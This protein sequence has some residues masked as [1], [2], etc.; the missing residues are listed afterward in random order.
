[1]RLGA[2]QGNRNDITRMARQIAK[3]PDGIV[4][5]AVDQMHILEMIAFLSSFSKI[6][7]QA[8]NELRG[9]VQPG[10]QPAGARLARD[11]TSFR[12]FQANMTLYLLEP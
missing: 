12:G 8:C 2:Q 11:K 9:I 6:K 10:T 4:C 5:F 7:K 3:R 1:M